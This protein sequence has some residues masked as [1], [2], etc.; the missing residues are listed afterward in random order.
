M[1]TKKTLLDL[2]TSLADKI[3]AGVVPTSS[4]KLAYWIRMINDGQQYC[5]DKLRLTKSTSLTTVSGTIALPDD[6]VVVVKV[7]LDGTP[8]KQIRKEGS[9]LAEGLCFWIDGN[10]LDGFTLNT[11]DDDTYD[12]FY[13][14]R[15]AEMALDADE[16]IIPDPVAVT[17]YAYSKLRMAQTDPL[18]D[19]DKEMG[20][21]ERRIRV[22]ESAVSFNEDGGYSFTL[23]N[24]A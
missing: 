8:L 18:E 19:A 7:T 23:Q 17:C 3:A 5:A 15:T 11:P 10:H 9:E 14:F 24:G 21:C 1:Y 13:N 20:E 12:V 22:M 16:C 2:K 6:F 4:V